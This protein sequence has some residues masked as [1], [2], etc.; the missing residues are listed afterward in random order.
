LAR[1]LPREVEFDSFRQALALAVN[2]VKEV[3]R[4]VTLDERLYAGFVSV[5]SEF[6][7]Y[8]FES[9]AQGQLFDAVK[10]FRELYDGDLQLALDENWR[11]EI[12]QRYSQALLRQLSDPY[13][14][15]YA[16]CAAV[17]QPSGPALRLLKRQQDSALKKIGEEQLL[18]VVSMWTQ[19]LLDRAAFNLQLNEEARYRVNNFYRPIQ[20]NEKISRFDRLLA[21]FGGLTEGEIQAL[22]ERFYLVLA[23]RNPAGHAFLKPSSLVLSLAMDAIWLQCA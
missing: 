4:E 21:Q 11:P 22:R 9:G 23:D 17:T 16:A 3:G 10:S 14:S 2:R 15:L 18:P 13:Y 20:W 7:L 5:C 1:D 8:F 19:Q 6:N 12:P